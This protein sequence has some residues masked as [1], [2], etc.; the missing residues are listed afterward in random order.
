MMGIFV[1]NSRSNGQQHSQ[2]TAVVTDGRHGSWVHLVMDGCCSGWLFIL[3]RVAVAVVVATDRR[4]ANP[5]QRWRRQGNCLRELLDSGFTKKV[6]LAVA[7]LIKT[8]CGRA[9]GIRHHVSVTASFF[10]SENGIFK[11]FFNQW[12]RFNRGSRKQI[13]TAPVG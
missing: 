12:H 1:T 2:R 3:Q 10:G 6:R 4:N 7:V 13:T 9:R 5:G 8:A 11:H